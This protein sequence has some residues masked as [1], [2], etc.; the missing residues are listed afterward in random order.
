MES[1]QKIMRIVSGFLKGKKIE[2]LKSKTTR[3]LRD[4]VKENIFNIMNHSNLINIKL[5]NANVLDLYSG[6]GSFGIECISQGA[7]KSTF[8]END[9]NALITL[10]KN[11][12]N[13][14]I[15]NQT[16]VFN[17]KITSFLNRFNNKVK[18]EIIFLDPPFAENFFLKEL[19]IIKDATIYK[20]NHLIII[21]REKKTKD[22]LEKIIN[23]HSTKIYGRS[24][25]IFGYF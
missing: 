3:P 25:V 12:N 6:V 23:I 7:K 13:L 18:F 16:E 14:N 22:D 2:F 1:S 4:F 10:K 11:L 9:N 8:V 21:H 15:G 17:G 5:E 19:K 24:K 20:K